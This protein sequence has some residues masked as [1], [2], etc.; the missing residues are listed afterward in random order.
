MKLMAED[1][2]HVHPG[3]WLL[4]EQREDV[5]SR[6]LQAHGVVKRAGVGLVRRLLQHRGEPEELASGR[7]VHDH[8]L[9]VVVHCGHLHA[10]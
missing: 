9:L 4:L 2:E 6:D 10:A 3:V 1:A 8:V 7:F 5:F